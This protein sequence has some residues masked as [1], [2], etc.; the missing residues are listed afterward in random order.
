MGVLANSK[1]A[2]RIDWDNIL[3]RYALLRGYDINEFVMEK[4]PMQ[5]LQEM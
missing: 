3:R 4:N 5:M 2:E 1:A